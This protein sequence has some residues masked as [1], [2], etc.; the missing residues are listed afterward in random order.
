[1]DVTAIDFKV[2]WNLEV[3]NLYKIFNTSLDSSQ[4]WVLSGMMS[5]HLTDCWV[6]LL[7]LVNVF[8]DEK[9]HFG[10]ETFHLLRILWVK[11]CHVRLWYF[12]EQFLNDQNIICDQLLDFFQTYLWCLVND[13]FE[14]I[15]EYE[16]KTL[17]DLLKRMVFFF[18]FPFKTFLLN[19]DFKIFFKKTFSFINSHFFDSLA[20]LRLFFASLF[21]Y[22]WSFLNDRIAFLE[23]GFWCVVNAVINCCCGCQSCRIRLH[24]EKFD[25]AKFWFERLERQDGLDE[26]ILSDLVNDEP[27]VMNKIL[28][29]IIELCNKS[30]WFEHEIFPFLW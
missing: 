5:H 28:V 14:L 3:F 24:V 19:N 10:T 29:C 12:E 23:F 9:G 4:C 18:E 25:R 17:N 21:Y 2:E 27:E 30:Q 11:N 16:H 1:M 26:L 20:C 22:K 15:L 13:I 6:D 8:L 7:M